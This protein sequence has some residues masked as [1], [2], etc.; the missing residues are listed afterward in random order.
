VG[1]VAGGEGMTAM[2]DALREWV[3]GI[4]EE[5]HDHLTDPTEE[6]P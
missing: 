4:L 5:F 2:A 6:T 3:A 1:P